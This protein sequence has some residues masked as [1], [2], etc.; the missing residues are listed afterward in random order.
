MK[1]GRSFIFLCSALGGLVLLTSGCVA[2]RKFVRNTVDPLDRHV[3]KVDQQ[4]AENKQDIRDLDKK[5]EAGI[6]QA[7]NSADQA[8]Q[9]AGNADQH[10]LAA[11][12]EAQKGIAAA[13]QAQETINNID[14]YKASQR[15]IVLF[16]F[17][18]STLTPEDKQHLDELTD[19]IKGLKHYAIQVQGYTDKTGPKKYN[20]QLS[21]ARANAVVRYL[22]LDHN[23]PLV[24][25]YKMGYGEASP[26]ASN[27][28]RKGRELN[29]RVEVTVM[30][31]QLPEQAGVP[32]SQVSS[33]GLSQ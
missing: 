7:Q 22:T 8:N 6:A 2:T 4:S 30:V 13:N 24:K 16:K 11:N 15:A 33:S 3:K 21:D 17:N 32:T 28:T 18:Q 31:P 19:A 25:I 27:S 10:A 5:T 1:S 23:I 9:A 26:T 12:Q 14:N 20:L 29:R